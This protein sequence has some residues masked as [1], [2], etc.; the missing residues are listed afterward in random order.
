[1][2]KNTSGK[3]RLIAINIIR[4]LL[5]AAFLGA[6]SSHRELVILFSIV[7]L[8]ATFFPFTE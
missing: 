8:A 2:E 1:M 5:V 3:F 6:L 4:L 7:G